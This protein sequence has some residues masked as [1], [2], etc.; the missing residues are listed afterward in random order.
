MRLQRF[1]RTLRWPT[2]SRAR[3]E[4]GNASARK[5]PNQGACC[6]WSCTGT[7]EKM[8]KRVLLILTVV[9]GLL[10]SGWTQT[11]IRVGAFPNITHPQAMA[12]K[13]NGWFERAMGPNVKIDWKSFNA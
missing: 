1:L 7:G 4:K 3:T 10:T 8:H 5:T 12:G 6:P 2:L 9:A 11:V 13:A